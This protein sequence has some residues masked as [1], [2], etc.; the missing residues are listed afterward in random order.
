MNYH[1]AIVI[2]ENESIEGGI[3]TLC[4]EHPSNHDD[5]CDIRIALS[6]IEY[7]RANL[8]TT[9]STAKDRIAEL[10]G[11]LDDNR[12]QYDVG[13]IH[14]NDRITAL[15]AE[16]T[17]A[18]EALKPF[19]DIYDASIKYAVREN[20]PFTLL[21]GDCRGEILL[22]DA[23]IALGDGGDAEEENDDKEML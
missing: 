15:K 8:K 20:K 13:L 10:E 5:E 1:E 6:V 4:G 7:E 14:M 19:A 3:C 21:L 22:R 16:L 17:V 2:L 12:K 11:A 23:K 9:L 18:R